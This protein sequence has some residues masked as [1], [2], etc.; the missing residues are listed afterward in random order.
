MKS[1]FAIVLLSI[2]LTNTLYSD[3]L[4]EEYKNKIYNIF[5]KLS[6]FASQEA[7]WLSSNI[8]SEQYDK[9]VLLKKSY[10]YY[11]KSSEVIFDIKRKPIFS[12][13]IDLYVAKDYVTAKNIF[14]RLTKKLHAKYSK[15]INFGQSSNIF[16]EPSNEKD[17]SQAL[18]NTLTI[19]QNFV[20]KISSHDGFAVMDFTEYMA[21][22][23]ANFIYQNIDLYKFNRLRV[24]AAINNKN[25]KVR[26]IYLINKDYKNIT[27]DGH[28]YDSHSK[29]ISGATIEL[30]ELGLKTK[31]DN[32]GAFSITGKLSDKGENVK[33]LRNFYFDLN[34]ENK[35]SNKY[36]LYHLI[37]TSSDNS[38][39]NKEDL[40]LKVNKSNK[41]TAF[42]Y[43]AKINRYETVDIKEYSK[44]KLI[45]IRDC[46]TSLFACKQYFHINID[47]K[48]INGY[49]DGFGGKALLKGKKITK[50][51]TKTINIKNVN[52][53]D[54]GIIISKSDGTT[55]ISKIGNLYTYNYPEEKSYIFFDCK[56]DNHNLFFMQR[57]YLVLNYMPHNSNKDATIEIYTAPNED[58]LTDS[59]N[60]I[61]S[62]TI[63][64]TISRAELK[65]N[66]TKYLRERKFNNE[67][68]LIG[69]NSPKTINIP[70]AG[71]SSST[72]V[73][74]S[75]LLESFMIE[76]NN[77][78]EK[79]ILSLSKDKEKD[80]ASNSNTPKKDGQA[81]IC[82][83][84][85]S[86]NIT[87]HIDNIEIT[88]EGDTSF[89]WN[90]D[91]N[92][93]YPG[94]VCYKNGSVINN[95]DY[96]LK[97]KDS[98]DIYIYKPEFFD[99]E[100]ELNYIIE[101]DNKKY[102]GKIE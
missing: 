75:V 61:K 52:N 99:T 62:F 55:H 91:I 93:I 7:N 82:I 50:R 78:K 81:D 51:T 32:S 73:M 101:I 77:S 12:V 96:N 3:T 43:L 95:C 30:L 49:R 19:N 13:N 33:L 74:P 89:K 22:N 39:N 53:C 37:L 69:V 23:V 17:F 68:L 26:E 1:L 79:I 65:I 5:P 66:I 72:D 31:T 29:G 57:A 28:V 56:L 41:E 10:T 16:I 9:Y 87:G 44:N 90:T 70:F 54:T 59:L 83:N 97:E 63:N 84:F 67:I 34:V 27:I 20:F 14:D 25:S 58:N 8:A 46:S 64:N 15:P 2:L 88:Y 94:I 85:S 98:F 48:N 76:K 36:D 45:F 47:G 80:L 38:D 40:Y 4:S 24:K 6:D 86:E 35:T 18:Y 60:K 102:K 71:L 21:R 100:K 92:D 42:L 11:S